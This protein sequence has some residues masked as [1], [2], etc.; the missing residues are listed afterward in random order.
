MLWGRTATLLGD[1]G[2]SAAYATALAVGDASGFK[3]FVQGARNPSD[4]SLLKPLSPA[5]LVPPDLDGHESAIVRAAAAVDSHEKAI[6]RAAAAVAGRLKSV[7][8]ESATVVHAKEVPAEALDVYFRH[9]ATRGD[10]SR[11]QQ[12]TVRLHCARAHWEKLTSAIKERVAIAR[13][14]GVEV[15]ATTAAVRARLFFCFY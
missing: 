9:G 13:S 15:T 6:V 8:D 14:H 11:E 7:L 4:D 12:R 1:S 2:R 10:L 3:D 5:A